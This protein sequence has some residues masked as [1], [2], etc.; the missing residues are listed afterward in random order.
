MKLGVLT[1]VLYSMDFA[2]AL[3]YLHGLGVETV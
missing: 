2:S 1:V 3:K